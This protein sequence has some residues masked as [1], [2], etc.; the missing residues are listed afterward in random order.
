MK[1]IAVK[2]SDEEVDLIQQAAESRMVTV[3]SFVRQVVRNYLNN[4]GENSEVT[5]AMI[6]DIEFIKN[7]ISE[8]LSIGIHRGLVKIY[9]NSVFSVQTTRHLARYLISD[10]R[11]FAQFLDEV[12]ELTEGHRVDEEQGKQ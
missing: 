10:D 4:P 8:L 3:S 12:R 7:G 9:S 6:E 11:K 1:T 5:K 2:V